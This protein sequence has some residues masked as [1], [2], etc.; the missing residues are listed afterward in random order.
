LVR[1]NTF[2]S[3]YADVEYQP[4]DF[5]CTDAINDHAARFVT[6]PQKHTAE[7]PFFMY[8]AHTAAHW[9]MHAKDADIAKYQG[10][11]ESG[12]DTIRTA[13]LE[14][15]RELGL[16][17]PRWQ[18]SPQAGDWSNVKDKAWESRCMEVFA[19]M[20]DCMDQ[21]IG[22]LVDTLKKIGQFELMSTCVDLADVSYPDEFD[23]Q[24]IQPMEGVSLMPAFAG[25]SLNRLN[26]IFWEHEGNRAIRVGDWKL[27]SKHPGD[28]ELYDIAADRTEMHDLATQEPARVKEMSSKWEAWAG[29]VGVRPWP[30]GDKKRK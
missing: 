29:R 14:K 18:V 26:P 17:D 16:L 8:V 28:W 2:I 10:R 1:D 30:L 19:A 13:R 20:L 24:S 7:K 6:E 15:M 23:G 25:P 9:P 3:P 27:V 4:Q 11:Y 12:Y 22:R 21:G 5:C